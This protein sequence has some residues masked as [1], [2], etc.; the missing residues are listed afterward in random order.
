MARKKLTPLQETYKQMKVINRKLD[1]LG[2]KVRKAIPYILGGSA[3]TAWAVKSVIEY[4]VARDNYLTN[5]YMELQSQAQYQAGYE[6]QLNVMNVLNLGD[7]TLN[8]QSFLNYLYGNDNIAKTQ[9]DKLQENNP[10]LYN[11]IRSDLSSFDDQFARERGFAD[12][13]EFSN[14]LQENY[15]ECI[16]SYNLSTGEWTFGDPSTLTYERMCE[17]AYIAIDL[18]QYRTSQVISNHANE[19]LS[20]GIDIDAMLNTEVQFPQ[21]EQEFE[22]FYAFTNQMGGQNLS[23]PTAEGLENYGVD[24]KISAKG[25]LDEMSDSPLDL[26]TVQL[27]DALDIGIAGALLAVGTACIADKAMQYFGKGGKGK[28][29]LGKLSEKFGDKINAVTKYIKND[30]VKDNGQEKQR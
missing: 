20:Q 8:R 23:H 5:A 18:Q 26:S 19:L 28:Q 11:N 7:V 25:L 15:P 16:A 30:K 13:G 1:G 27:E 17:V 10:E 24:S 3:F 6:F 29:A 2:A 21:T 9:W 12:Y 22:S 14:Y 4:N